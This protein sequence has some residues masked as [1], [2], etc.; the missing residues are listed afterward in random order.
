MYQCCSVAGRS[1]E[2]GL[3][4]RQSIPANASRNYVATAS[5]AANMMRVSLPF[6]TPCV[7]CGGP[8]RRATAEQRA[9]WFWLLYLGSHILGGHSSGAYRP[10]D[11]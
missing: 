9:M 7:S 8:D 3:G 5:S 4:L 1:G 10:G 2:V 11:S 6:D